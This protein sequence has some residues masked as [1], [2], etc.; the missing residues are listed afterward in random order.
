M[1]QEEAIKDGKDGASSVIPWTVPR[2]R[3]GPKDTRPT[4]KGGRPPSVL[5]QLDGE[6][7]K[8]VLAPAPTEHAPAAARPVASRLDGKPPQSAAEEVAAARLRQLERLLRT[9]EE[10]LRRQE[11]EIS[12][13]Q[14]DKFGLQRDNREMQLFLADYGM[15][16]VGGVGEASAASSTAAQ[17]SD[18]SEA[19]GAAA[20]VASRAACDAAPSAS[21][22]ASASSAAL[23][24]AKGGGTGGGTSTTKA[25]GGSPAG[26]SA[27]MPPDMDVVR[28]A[29]HELNELADSSAEVVQR[30]DGSHRLQQSQPTLSLIFW[31]NGM[32]VQGG[33]LRPYGTP[34]CTSFLKDLL[35]GFFPYELKYAFPDGVI[36]SVQD[37]SHVDNDQPEHTWGQGRRL[38][39]RGGAAVRG[40]AAARGG[41]AGASLLGIDAGRM[42]SLGPQLAAGGAAAELVAEL[43]APAPADVPAAPTAAVPVAAT[44]LAAP[45]AAVAAPAAAVVTHSS[46]QTADGDSGDSGECRL[47]IKD[48][49][50]GVACVMTLPSKAT[51]AEVHQQLHAR[52]CKEIPFLAARCPCGHPLL[53]KPKKAQPL[54]QRS[55]LTSPAALSAWM[56]KRG[57]GGALL[58]A[59]S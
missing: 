55:P 7:E 52:M 50:G 58:P 16:W 35:D 2:N 47:Q 41:A 45:A 26:G 48:S 33:E 15:R 4:L 49:G 36:F 29:V 19:R 59:Q 23:P 57:Y 21:C 32:E 46:E 25:A 38:D 56:P 34:Q 43:V 42:L 8:R 11:R 27:S 10:E 22:S 1:A 39:S 14:A 37:R 13:L 28:R 20:G 3:F 18:G 17:S 51:L 31:R 44:P 40:G 24:A 9:Q 54:A 12:Q 53:Q 30:D 6:L 5:D